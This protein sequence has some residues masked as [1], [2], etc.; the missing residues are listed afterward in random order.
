MPLY[1]Y[2]CRTCGNKFEML[3]RI[4]DA[5]QYLKCPDCRSEE[6]DRQLSTF[7]TRGC[8]QFSSGRFT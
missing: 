5:D 3:R 2:R 6:V 4:Q 1:E 8:G 7:A